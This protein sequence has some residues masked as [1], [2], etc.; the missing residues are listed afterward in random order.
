M[1]N[2]V[3]ET[4]RLL[5]REFKEGESDLIYDLDRDPDVMRYIGS[6][7]TR[8]KKEAEEYLKNIIRHYNQYG[9]G[10]WAVFLKNNETFAGWCGLKHLENTNKIELGYRLKKKYWGIGIAT[11]ASKAVLDYGFRKLQLDHIIAIALPENKKSL[12]V[13]KK[14][15]MT[16][17]GNTLAYGMK[18]ILFEKKNPFIQSS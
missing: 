10:L 8:N 7:K 11:E 4:D 9:F 16:E 2:K 18:C 5:I 17:T 14:L 13:L 6:G 1:G 15:K 12:S 3:L